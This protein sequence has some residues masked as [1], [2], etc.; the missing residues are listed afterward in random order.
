MGCSESS[1]WS[2]LTIFSK[3]MT[4]VRVREDV[5]AMQPPATE[6]ALAV[7]TAYVRS[8]RSPVTSA[9]MR[10]TDRILVGPERT[11]PLA[12]SLRK[13]SFAILTKLR[14]RL[15]YFQLRMKVSKSGVWLCHY[16]GF[17]TECRFERYETREGIVIPS[18]AVVSGSIGQV[19]WRLPAQKSLMRRP[20]V[21]EPGLPA[22]ATSETRA[23]G[24]TAIMS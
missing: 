12:V 9:A 19:A 5:S 13:S 18:L 2:E 3:R 23:R 4:N 6:I 22:F 10:D 21:F 7:T 17:G 16:F 1:K 24:G 20:D 11:C 14:N 15:N 8:L